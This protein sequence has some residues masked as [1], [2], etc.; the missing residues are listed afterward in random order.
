MDIGLG[1]SIPD[2]K[3]YYCS[4]LSLLPL[5]SPFP[6][7]ASSVKRSDEALLAKRM[8]LGLGEQL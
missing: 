3:C 1:E 4:S 5:P 6:V 8:D 7:T 2:E